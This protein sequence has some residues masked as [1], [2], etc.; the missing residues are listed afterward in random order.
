VIRGRCC[1]DFAPKGLEKLAQG[2]SPG[3]VEK[4]GALK[5]APDGIWLGSTVKW[6]FKLIICSED[7]LGRR[8]QGDLVPLATQG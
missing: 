5:V 2:F 6:R 1:S 3:L 8:F 4:R 7:H